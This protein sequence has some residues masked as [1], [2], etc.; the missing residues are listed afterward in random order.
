M[1]AMSTAAYALVVTLCNGK[2][3][4]SHFSHFSTLLGLCFGKM[5][6]ITLAITFKCNVYLCFAV[7]CLVH[8]A[9]V[10]V[11]DVAVRC[12]EEALLPCKVLQDSLVTYQTVSWYKV[13]KILSYLSGLL[14]FP[15]WYWRLLYKNGLFYEVASSCQ[16]SRDKAAMRAFELITGNRSFPCHCRQTERNPWIAPGLLFYLTIDSLQGS[17]FRGCPMYSLPNTTPKRSLSRIF[18]ETLQHYWYCCLVNLLP[19][20][21]FFFLFSLKWKN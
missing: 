8:G 16:G 19:N 21:R 1:K 20:R 11:P 17:E 5:G 15:T 12:A 10:T 14:C 9:A 4:A 13:R 7:W 6:S 3:G 2:W 18:L